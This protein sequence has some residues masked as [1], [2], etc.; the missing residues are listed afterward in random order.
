[1]NCDTAREGKKIREEEE[2][3]REHDEGVQHILKEI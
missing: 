1:L 2:A 3:W